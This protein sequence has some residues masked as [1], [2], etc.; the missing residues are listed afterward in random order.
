MNNSNYRFHVLVNDTKEEITSAS[1]DDFHNIYSEQD[2][3]A[4]E[5]IIKAAILNLNQSCQ[6]AGLTITRIK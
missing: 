3:A 6:A 5:C 2:R 1:L 4:A